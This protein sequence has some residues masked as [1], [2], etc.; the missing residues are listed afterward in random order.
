MAFDAIGRLL[1]AVQT[2]ARRAGHRTR[3]T[4]RQR[5]IEDRLLRRYVRDGERNDREELIRRFMPLARK[6]ASRYVGGSESREDLVQVANLALVKAVDGF[7]PERGDSFTAYA[8]PTILG[9]LRR[10]F[11]DRVWRIHLSRGLQERTLAVDKA[12]S[13]LTGRNGREPTVREVA[14]ELQLDEEEVLEALVASDA[15]RVGS[16]DAPVSSE[17]DES[18]T[19]LELVGTEESGYGQVEA[20]CAAECA[21]LT[22]REELVLRLRFGAGLTQSEI[23]ERLG[24][25]QMQISRISRGAVAKL[26]AAV[27]GEGEDASE[28]LTAA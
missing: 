13:K 5:Q 8:V 3:I 24:V 23:G 22:E 19:R 14:E 6:L 15:G 1:M 26:L 10:H 18:M 7:N 27:R 4:P 16:L 12:I 20:Q 28:T 21:E 17:T 25:S 2:T 11:R 9:E